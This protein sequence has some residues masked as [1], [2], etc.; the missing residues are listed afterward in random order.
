MLRRKAMMKTKLWGIKLY[1]GDVAFIST[2][3]GKI[4][5]WGNPNLLYVPIFRSR[6]EAM[7]FGQRAKRR[8][9]AEGVQTIEVRIV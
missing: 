8:F 4:Y 7:K 5:R 6:K 1:G 2:S 9:R 3:D